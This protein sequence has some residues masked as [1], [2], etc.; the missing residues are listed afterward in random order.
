MLSGHNDMEPCTTFISSDSESG[1]IKGRPSAVIQYID[2]SG[3][4]N[5][6]TYNS[7]D[8]D[9]AG[10][11]YVNDYNG[12]LVFSHNDLSKIGRAHV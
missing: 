3:I 11:G 6:W 5:Y 8:V 7:Q 9:R 1:L 4:E 2:N 10:T 12:N